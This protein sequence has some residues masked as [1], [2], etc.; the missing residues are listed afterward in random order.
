MNWTWL[1]NQATRICLVGLFVTL[2][3][4]VSQAAAPI[5]PVCSWPFE[6]SGQGLTNI[7]MPDT[8]ATYWVMPLDTSNWKAMVIHGTYPQARFFNFNTYTA[9][10]S[11]I[12]TL[13]DTQIAPDSGSWNPFAT[14]TGTGAQDYTVEIS[15]SNLGSGNFLS[16]GGGGFAFVVYRVYLAD[17][18][19]DRTGGVG[20][21]TVSLVDQSGNTRTLQS[22][23]F[24]SAETSLPNLIVLLRTSG[25]T[26]AANF[27]EQILTAANQALG[28]G[29]CSVSSKNPNPVTFPATSGAGFFPNPQTTYLQTG[30]LCFQPGQVLVVRGKAAVYP[31]TYTSPP[32]SVFQPAFDG[33]IQLR[34]WSMCNNDGTIPYPAVACQADAMTDLD[35]NQFY[36][37]VISGDMSPPSGLPSGTTWLPWGSTSLPITLIFRNLLPEPG[38]TASG[39]YVPVGVFCSEEGF[40]QYGWQGCFNAAGVPA[41]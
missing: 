40:T 39:A 12:G 27:L 37:Y 11:L 36:T 7:G 17:P 13:Y 10:G 34:Y 24:A 30:N 29:T 1:A 28:G 33:Q 18:G 38:F 5:L 21:P 19:L 9:T 23:P 14:P 35:Q 32:G 2:V 31:N 26:D 3:V 25:F 16:A 41:P 8:N 4:S 6:A 20:V 22:C 15:P